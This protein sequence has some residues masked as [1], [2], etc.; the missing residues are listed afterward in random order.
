MFNIGAAIPSKVV[1]NC[2]FKKFIDENFVS[3][4]TEMQHEY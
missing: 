1:T 2:R 3:Q 4:R